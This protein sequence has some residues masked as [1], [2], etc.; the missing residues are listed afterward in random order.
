MNART[1]YERTQIVIYKIHALLPVE[2]L[3]PRGA[4]GECDARILVRAFGE[5]ARNLRAPIHVLR[6]RGEIE[7][8]LGKRFLN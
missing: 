7:I 6:V 2:L 8:E 1:L 4:N 3:H 5:R